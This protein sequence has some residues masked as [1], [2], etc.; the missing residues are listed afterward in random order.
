M[1]TPRPPILK[2]AWG[3]HL[4]TPP[5]LTPM[6][7]DVIDS[8]IG[9]SVA[10]QFLCNDN[11]RLSSP[12]VCPSSVT[13]S[14]APHHL[15]PHHLLPHHLLPHPLLPHHLLP[16]H[17]LPHHLLHHRLLPRHLLPRHLLPIIFSP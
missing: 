1:E 4:P 7:V 9:K 5:G 14:S 13:P 3:L 15:L 16:H 17:L 11:N 10:L 12:N 6:E 8:Y 2:S